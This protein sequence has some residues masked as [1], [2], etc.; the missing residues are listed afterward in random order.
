MK[1]FKKL[2]A[3]FMTLAMLV[4][5]LPATVLADDVKTY[6][7]GEGQTY[8][9][10]SDAVAQV[11][12]DSAINVIY[13]IYGEVTINAT[14]V[15]SVAGSTVESVAF[16]GVGN[17]AALT[18]NAAATSNYLSASADKV[19]FENLTLERTG[20]CGFAGNIGFLGELFGIWTSGEV[21]YTECDFPEGAVTFSPKTTFTQCEFVSA[22]NPSASKYKFGLWAY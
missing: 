1:K 8:E 16:V 12:A 13:E 2:L 19:S 20:A 4:T 7:V 10:L 6:S 15:Y 18:F 9:T 21:T 3:G 22:Y 5:M 14:G 11:S 17:G